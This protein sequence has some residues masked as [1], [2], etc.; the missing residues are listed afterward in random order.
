VGRAPTPGSARIHAHVAAIRADEIHKGH[1]PSL[2]TQHE[3]V[4]VEQLAAKEHESA[5]RTPA[6]V[7]SNRGALGDAAVGRNPHS[8]RLQNLVVRH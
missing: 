7:A 6:S 1:H 8:T 4:G 2:A 5:R 3:V